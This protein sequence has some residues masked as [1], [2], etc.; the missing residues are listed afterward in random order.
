[1]ISV[2]K[3][4]GK[5]TIAELALLHERIKGKYPRDLLPLMMDYRV[6]HAMSDQEIV[7]IFRIAKAFHYEAS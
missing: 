4:V 2:N 7:I 6:H 1:M 3:N 5:V